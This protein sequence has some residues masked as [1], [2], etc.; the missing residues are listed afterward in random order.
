MQHIRTL[1]SENGGKED[2]ERETREI[3]IVARAPI[4]GQGM[5]NISNLI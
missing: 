5:T 4:S 3:R 2:S 1:N